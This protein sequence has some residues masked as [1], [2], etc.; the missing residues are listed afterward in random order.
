MAIAYSLRP[1]SRVKLPVEIVGPIIDELKRQHATPDNPEGSVTRE[2]VF[3]AARPPESPLHAHFEWDQS[4][5]AYQYNLCQANELIICYSAKF[6][7]ANEPPIFFN[8]ANVHIRTRENAPVYVST[9]YAMSQPD[10]RAQVL[11]QT[12]AQ[13]AGWERRLA[14]LEGITPAILAALDQLKAAI[15]Q[16]KR[17]PLPAAGKRPKKPKAPRPKGPLPPP[18]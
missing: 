17:K 18:V 4:E 14:A 10:Y 3:E 12:L 9:S 16:A 11:D 2:E 6:Q 5:A 13:I 7:H 1:F 15:A 8:P